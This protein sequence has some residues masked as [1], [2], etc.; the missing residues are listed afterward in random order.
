MRRVNYQTPDG[1]QWVV[2]LPDEADD[3]EAAQGVPVGPPDL[4][5]LG[6]PDELLGRLHAELFHRR[7]LTYKDALSRSAEVRAAWQAAL[8]ADVT[9]ILRVYAGEGSH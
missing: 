1:R 4:A 7:I 6:L 3:S 8:R 9:D 2:E 5:G